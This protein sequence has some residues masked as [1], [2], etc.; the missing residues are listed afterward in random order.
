M[1]NIEELKKKFREIFK[2]DNVRIFHSPGRVNLLG[3]HTDYNGGYVL[4]AA[5]NVGTTVCISKRD[6]KKIVLK[7]TDL[8]DVVSADIDN[9]LSYRNIRWGNYQLGVAY[10]LMKA[11]YKVGGCNM[12]FDDAVPHGAGLSSSA[13][14]EC[15][16]GIALIS[17]FNPER[18]IDRVELALLAQKAEN[19]FVG[20]NCGI[21]DQFAS[22]MGKKDNAIFLN[23][24]TLE[25]KYVP[26][27]L[28]DYVLVITNTN[29]K[30]SLADSKYNERR[31][32]CEKGL[33]FLKK[34]LPYITC[35]GEITVDIFESIREVIKD[36]V[37][38]KRV[39]HVIYEDDRVLK[40]I[41]VLSK[42]NLSEFGKLMIESHISLRDL[43]EVTGI[44]LDT[45]F[46]ESLKVKGVLGTRMTGAG[47][48]GCTVSIVHKSAI[49]DFK[50]YVGENY[51]LKTGLTPDFYVMETG[52]GAREIC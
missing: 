19:Q 8:D 52:E 9:L 37:V 16:T 24:R 51:R 47:F 46:E 32:E 4:P 14:I 49:D 11:G 43:Y 31:A 6:D 39:R 48:G 29:K 27:S 34:E 10:E 26:L 13:A 17:M 38:E 18:E 45:L 15:A 22:I 40:A 35:L 50:R 23:C 41:E 36:P 30:R 2:D 33:E 20:V 5:L 12:L 1:S 25:Y 28:G 21:M 7:A 3:E 44:E 42:G